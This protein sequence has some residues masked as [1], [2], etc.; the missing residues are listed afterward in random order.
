MCKTNACT[1]HSSL[2]L[3][4]LSEIDKSS[5]QIKTWCGRLGKVSEGGGSMDGKKQ[6]TIYLNIDK[7]SYL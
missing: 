3:Q 1:V 2:V 6:D 7:Y 4:D 5:K